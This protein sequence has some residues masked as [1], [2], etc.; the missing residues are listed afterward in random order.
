[1][2]TNSNTHFI[3]LKAG[4]ILPYRTLAYPHIS[5]LQRSAG[6][7]N[8]N[9]LSTLLKIP[10]AATWFKLITDWNKWTGLNAPIARREVLKNLGNTGLEGGAL[11]GGT[12][13]QQKEL[14]V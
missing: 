4:L 1:M 10:R 3:A 2:F 8:A 6:I 11:A 7:K 13:L 14:K 5:A 12:A 9:S